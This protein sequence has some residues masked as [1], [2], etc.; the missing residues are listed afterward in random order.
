MPTA[1]PQPSWPFTA[2]DH[3]SDVHANDKPQPTYFDHWRLV[4]EEKSETQTEDIRFL[5]R[6]MIP[7]PLVKV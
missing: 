5:G 4:T 1:S 3:A 7:I 2:R 6:A